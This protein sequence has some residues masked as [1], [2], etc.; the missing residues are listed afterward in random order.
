MLKALSFA[1]VLHEH[2]GEHDSL[3]LIR[4]RRSYGRYEETGVESAHLLIA[5]TTLTATRVL[6]KAGQLQSSSELNYSIRDLYDQECLPILRQHFSDQYQ[7]VRTFVQAFTKDLAVRTQTVFEEIMMIAVT[8]IS[9]DLL[10]LTSYSEECLQNYVETACHTESS[11]GAGFSSPNS[12]HNALKVTLENGLNVWRKNNGNIHLRSNRVLRLG[13]LFLSAS[14][15]YKASIAFQTGTPGISRHQNEQ[16]FLA[17]LSALSKIREAEGIAKP[18]SIFMPQ[19][20][21]AAFY[22]AEF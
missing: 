16:E 5:Q 2:L 12:Q 13:R 4:V 15:S 11:V 17:A 7:R 6:V 18:P 21:S 20:N 1:A 3:D 22:E 10:P 9:P 8:D 19:L 14:S